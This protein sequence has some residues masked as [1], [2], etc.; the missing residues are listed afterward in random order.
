MGLIFNQRGISII[1]VVIMLLIMAVMGSVLLS[2][3][4]TENTSTVGQMRGDQ[5]YYVAET[6]SEYGQRFMT[7]TAN[8]YFFPTDP[9]TIVTNNPLGAGTFTAILNF[10]ATALSKNIGNGNATICVFSVDRLPNPAIIEIDNEIVTCS[11]TGACAST[12]ALTGCTRGGGQGASTHSIGAEVYPVTTVSVAINTTVTTIQVGSTAK[13]LSSGTIQIGD[14]W[15][16][17][18]PENARYNG[19]DA[20]HFYGVVRGVDGT[21]PT[22]WAINTDIT[23]L[24][25]TGA[26]P[27]DEVLIMSTGT[28]SGAN[29]AV[30]TVAQE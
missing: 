24:Q 23:P 8:W 1:A 6:G 3:V 20:T 26:P 18:P 10:P 5:A 30:Q 25:N 28:V 15:G 16:A 27:N 4:G 22:A 29:R 7:D 13:F 14:S 11:G 21:V 2:M 9:Y 12:P 19:I 17:T